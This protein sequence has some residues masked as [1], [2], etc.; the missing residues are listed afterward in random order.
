MLGKSFVGMRAED[1]LVAVR[2][3]RRRAQTKNHP[4]GKLHLIAVGE[5]GPVG[6]HAMAV[7]PQV[8]DRLTLRRSLTSWK[9]V[10]TIPVTK[11]QLPNVVHGALQSYDLPDLVEFIGPKRI[12]IEDPVDAAQNVVDAKSE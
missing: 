3:L 9:S 2:Y 5:A 7:E 4:I 11:G 12:T 6:L 10:V 1:I 8:F